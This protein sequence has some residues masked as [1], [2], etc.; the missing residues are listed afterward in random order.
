M[1]KIK[2]NELVEQYHKHYK[3]S[4]PTCL[5]DVIKLIRAYAE[6]DEKPMDGFWARPAF[7]FGDLV[8]DKDTQSLGICIKISGE[9]AILLQRY[10]PDGTFLTCTR[11][12]S[13]LE[14]IERDC[15]LYSFQTI[16]EKLKGDC[17]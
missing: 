3:D 10:S 8:K 16:L 13:H 7:H 6:R 9:I 1:G 12:F 2:F 5:G 14:L 15:H 11:E 4:A 17:P